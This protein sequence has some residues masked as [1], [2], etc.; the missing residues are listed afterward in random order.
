VAG[1]RHLDAQEA[2]GTADLAGRATGGF[3]DQTL[4]LGLLAGQLA[5]P[6]DGLTGLAGALFGGFFVG[7]AA[8]HFA[9]Q[10]LALQ[11]LLQDLDG[12]VDIVV[13]DDDLQGTS[14]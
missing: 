9:K 10:P 1:S 5:S 6:A 14:P 3:R 7:A 12:L 2:G 11:F 4:A 13:T 8:F